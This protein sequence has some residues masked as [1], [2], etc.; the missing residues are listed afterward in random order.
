[1]LLVDFPI[2][3]I[4]VQICVKKSA[5]LDYTICTIISS[6]ENLQY[7]HALVVGFHK[8]VISN[9]VPMHSQIYARC[10]S[11]L[12]M[13]NSHYFKFMLRSGELSHLYKQPICTELHSDFTAF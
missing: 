2:V 11:I 4:Y 7:Q 8:H 3:W 9:C 1:M 5:K 12:L 13:Q 10:A 6:L